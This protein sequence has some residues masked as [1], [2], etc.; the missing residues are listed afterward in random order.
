MLKKTFLLLAS[1]AMTFAVQAQDLLGAWSGKLDLRTAKLSL[2]FHFSKD[3]S[4]KLKC[5]MDSPDLS[6]TAP[7]KGPTA[8][9]LR[10]R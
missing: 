9:L 5:V 8:F 10:L 6:W 4:G 7:T 2:V 1:L 3:D